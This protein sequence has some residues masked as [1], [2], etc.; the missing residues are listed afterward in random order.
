MSGGASPAAE[1]PIASQGEQSTIQ[2]AHRRVVAVRAAPRKRRPSHESGT[3]VAT[4]RE[5]IFTRKPRSDSRGPLQV[6]TVDCAREEHWS[7]EAVE[8]SMTAHRMSERRPPV[9]T[10][11]LAQGGTEVT[12]ER[13]AMLF[14][15][16][17]VVPRAR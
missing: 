15:K 17:S 4:T 1:G 13:G 6:M 3:E 5:A 7:C 14:V 12:T 2:K 8:Q 9:N 10:A 16:Q 11:P